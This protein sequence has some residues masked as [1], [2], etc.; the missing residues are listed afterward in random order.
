[1]FPFSAMSDMTRSRSRSPP[2]KTRPL[3]A[4]RRA[5]FELGMD[6]S[7]ASR[8]PTP[9]LPGTPEL[10]DLHKT[11]S[12]KT[13][14]AARLRATV[15]RPAT[16]E[17]RHPRSFE[18]LWVNAVAGA[19]RAFLLAYGIRAGLN[20]VVVVLRNM[21]RG[22][23]PLALL[24]RALFAES[25]VNFGRVFGAFVRVRHQGRLSYRSLCGRRSLPGASSSTAWSVVSRPL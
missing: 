19:S 18:Q 25:A 20:L 17:R 9:D 4:P 12:F 8:P 6:Y 2:P 10:R 5:G 23:L 3:A 15:W 24:Q 7:L 13:L 22:R 14:D 16:E 21:K 11:L 1:M